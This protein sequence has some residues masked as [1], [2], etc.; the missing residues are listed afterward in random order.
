MQASQRMSL[1]KLALAVLL[2][3][4]CGDDAEVV[5]PVIDAGAD[6]GRDAGAAQ[7]TPAP[8]DEP[9]EML[10]QWH[11]FEDIAAQAPS[12]RVLPYT[13]NAELY[14]DEAD[15]RRFMR[16]PEGARIEYAS[17]SAWRFPVGTILVKTFLYAHPIVD[18]E[19]S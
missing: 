4:A 1:K 6:A 7:I 8:E 3:V 9:W 13:V 19:P 18:G 14:A 16:I 12:D 17:D 15:K 11:L 2:L 10:S 5:P